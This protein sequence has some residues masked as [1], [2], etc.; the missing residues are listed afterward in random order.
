MPEHEI[1][2]V[3]VLLAHD[4]HEALLVFHHGVRPGVAPVAPRVVGDGGG[5]MSDVVVCGHDEARVHERDD[6]VEVAAGM[7]AEAVD[8]LDDAL[9]LAGRNVDPARDLIAVV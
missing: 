9:G 1:G 8:E 7:L 4:I 2:E 6:H 3:G 5:A